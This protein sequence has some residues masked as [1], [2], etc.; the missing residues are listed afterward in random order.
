[1][2]N[3]FLNLSL[4]TLLLGQF[5]FADE[6]ENKSLEFR[7]HFLGSIDTTVIPDDD[8]LNRVKD[9]L[10]YLA[11]EKLLDEPDT[12]AS[13]F[14]SVKSK[15]VASF[16]P[17]DLYKNGIANKISLSDI[18]PIGTDDLLSESEITI[19]LVPGVFGEFI[20]TKAFHEVVN[21][22]TSLFRDQWK[23]IP[24]AKKGT[25]ESF[26]LNT[27]NYT[28][29]KSGTVQRPLDDLV[30]V[31]SIDSEGKILVRYILLD[32]PKWSTESLGNIQDVAQKY[33]R[34]LQKVFN[35][36]GTPKNIV[37][38][39]YSR[40][41]MTGLEM[42]S[43]ADNKKATWLMNVKGMVSL[44]GVVFGSNLADQMDTAKSVLNVQNSE[45]KNLL[46]DLVFLPEI[47]STDSWW[48]KHWTKPGER[49]KLL[50]KN[51]G[52]WTSFLKKVMEVS[53]INNMERLKEL[54][55]MNAGTDVR[56]VIPQ[57]MSSSDL[58]LKA[59]LANYNSN[60]KKFK[61][62]A[63]KIIEA[64]S[65]L[66][67]SSRIQWWQKHK[68]PLHV[69]YYSLSAVM[70]DYKNPI[71]ES[72]GKNPYCYNFPSTDLGMLVENYRDLAK[73]SG[74]LTLNDSQMS[75]EKTIF[76]PNLIGKLNVQN[77]GMKSVFLGVLGTHH[78]GIALQTVN[79][80]RDKAGKPNMNPFPRVAILKAIAATAASVE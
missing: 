80:E 31:S 5:S 62:F 60:L 53:K 21:T 40:G 26:D 42:L 24:A 52:R 18:D 71:E 12:D 41:T 35:L 44:G 4:L 56:A 22:K 46:K 6:M 54:M 63:E 38:V 9:Y 45:V 34:R 49:N 28:D 74:G 69:T 76:W 27:I 68:I 66:K 16:Q 58:F 30:K 3:I 59:P 2:K 7:K 43:Q 48:I 23:K 1:M 14:F 64:A 10:I 57:I 61:L 13:T 25:D 15:T 72:L 77:E 55:Q 75:I 19:V 47:S 11:P 37:F 65:E 78:W 50:L 33:N 17:I 67:T 29:P 70:A 20:D 36:I 79:Q 8:V 73:N 32:M 51:A 39:G